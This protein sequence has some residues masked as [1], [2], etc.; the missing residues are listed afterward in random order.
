M[1]EVIEKKEGKRADK[2][3]KKFM[4]IDKILER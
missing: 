2:M 3:M 4:K 1:E